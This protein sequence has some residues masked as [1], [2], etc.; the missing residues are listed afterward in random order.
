MCGFVR[1]FFS[2]FANWILTWNTDLV[3]C[4]LTIVGSLIAT[5]V[6]YCHTKKLKFY[7]TFFAEKVKA[8]SEFID[9]VSMEIR[10]NNPDGLKRVIA[11]QMKVKLYCSDRARAEVTKVHDAFMHMEDPDDPTELANFGAVYDDA[12]NVFR[13]DVHSCRKFKFE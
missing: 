10:G 11:A 12:V 13:E 8:Y 5:C 6:T 7:E 1:E 4:G 9:V 2:W 3:V